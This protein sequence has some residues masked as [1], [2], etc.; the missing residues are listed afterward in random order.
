MGAFNDTADVLNVGTLTNKGEVFVAVGATL[1]LTNEPNGVTDVGLG[2]S[3]YIAGGFKAGA[4]SALAKV[5]SVE[6]VLEIEN[7]Q[8]TTITPG[9]GT[10]T[11]TGTFDVERNSTVT[12]SGNVNNSGNFY[13]NQQNN[14]VGVNTVT[15]TGTLTNNAGATAYVGVFNDTSDVLNVGTLTNKGEVVVGVGAALNLTNEP[16][17]VT[18][19]AVGS[20]YYIAGGFKAG[21][22]SAVAKLGSVEGLME[23][24]N[25]QSTTITPG[26]GT[27]TN[28]GTFDVERN[29]TVTISGNVNNSASFYTNQ[30]NNGVGPDNT[31][32]VTGALTNNAGARYRR[33]ASLMTPLTC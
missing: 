29:S 23:I 16:N 15:V 11:N 13:T 27:L 19:V 33:G 30:Q 28:T 26:G 10:L 2:S 7:G 25:G 3:Y 8:S 1:N 17:G 32:T 20:S 9:G 31:V 12:V 21:A 18:D 22:A 6:G 24:E 14:G 5:G 4:A